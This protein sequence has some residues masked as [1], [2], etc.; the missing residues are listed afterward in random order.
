M[1]S[2]LVNRTFSESLFK[3]NGKADIMW[4]NLGAFALMG[5]RPPAPVAG[6]TKLAGGFNWLEDAAID[7][8]SAPWRGR[9]GSS[10]SAPSLF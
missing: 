8:R 1:D 7:S 3:A 2:V 9:M 4:R 5:H 10:R 6:V